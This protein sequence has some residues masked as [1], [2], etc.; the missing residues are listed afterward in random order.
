[1]DKTSAR[2]AVVP[3]DGIG[4]EVTAEAIKIVRCIGDVHGRG[5][6]L[7][8]RRARRLC[9]AKG[10]TPRPREQPSQFVKKGAEIYQK[11]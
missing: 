3:G 9:A 1:M 4:V 8:G 10:R 5:F 7:A 11:S 6:E 2:I